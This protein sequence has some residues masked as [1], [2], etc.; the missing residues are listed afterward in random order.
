MN[1]HMSTDDL[2]IERK[3]KELRR[4]RKNK[5]CLNR[6]YEK[7]DFINIKMINPQAFKV[8]GMPRGGTPVTIGDLLIE[9]NELEDRIARMKVKGDKIKK[10]ILNEIDS[11]DDYRYC[12]ILEGYF[13]ECKSLEDIALEEGYTIRHVYRLYKKG[14]ELLTL[15]SQ[16]DDI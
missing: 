3:K 5:E 2:K 4:Y 15:N 10:K 1:E 7:L 8:S 12:E 13:I 9:K 11:L 14:I 16:K 6:L